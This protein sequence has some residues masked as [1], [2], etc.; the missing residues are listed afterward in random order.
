MACIR[1]PTRTTSAVTRTGS[2]WHQFVVGAFLLDGP[3][4]QAA[5]HLPTQRRTPAAL[6]DLV[7]N[8]RVRFGHEEGRQGGRLHR[9]VLG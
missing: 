8:E 9:G 2:R 7:R 5:H 4:E 1:L 3:G 6:S